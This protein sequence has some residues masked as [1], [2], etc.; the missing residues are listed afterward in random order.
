MRN[1]RPDSNKTF[2]MTPLYKKILFLILVILIG[3]LFIHPYHN[4]H[5]ALTQGDNG[6][7]LYGFK[8]TFEGGTPYRDYWWVYGPLMPYYYGLF[9]QLFGISIHSVLLGKLLLVELCGVVIYLMLSLFITPWLALIAAV[10]FWTFNPDF[11]YT[12]NHIGGILMLL[13]TVYSLFLYI[14]RPRN[15]YVYTGLLSVFI[16]GLIKINIGLSGLAALVLSL[17]VI[18]F[19]RKYLP[20]FPKKRLYLL[21]VSIVTLTLLTYWVFL[22]GLPLDY[23]Q[24]C[25]PGSYRAPDYSFWIPFKELWRS[26]VSN[27]LS[28]WPNIFF[29]LIIIFSSLQTLNLL[30][31]QQSNR[32][33]KTRIS[34][35][36]I[37]LALFWSF[38]LHELIVSGVNYRI[39]WITPLNTILIFTLIHMGTKR[40]S[41][42]VKFLLC[43]T[44]AL[45]AS[46]AMYG[47]YQMIQ[48][49]KTPPQYLSLESEKVYVTND[50]GWIYTVQTT[51]KYL[52]DHLKSGETFLALPYDPLYYF[53][54]GKDSPI[55]EL[56]FFEHIKISQRQ[57]KEII[58]RLESR[59][60][61][62][63]LMS[64]RIDSPVPGLGVF[65]KTYCPLLARYID[66]H[67]EL[68]AVFGDWQAPPR[69]PWSHHGTK[70]FRRIPP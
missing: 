41:R 55:R 43:I 12:Y 39:Y 30:L 45:L 7:D 36:F 38:N 32:E 57:E 54:V 40:L 62:W 24:Q 49:F 65:G 21:S 48:S 13:T 2:F 9:Y 68:D 23:L 22:R 51:T 19:S 35:I 5:I 33:F 4:L 34:L 18:D 69:E 64:S 52:R 20:V 11:V 42:I 53:L 56:Y 6:R 37:T 3:I 61:N 59:K 46:L 66:E 67:F 44:L 60:V 8:K 16:L 25:Y 14:K 1:N 10:W 47:K 50:W 58:A 15:L 70:V 63:I 28:S 26:N 17:H 31:Q 27:F 29:G